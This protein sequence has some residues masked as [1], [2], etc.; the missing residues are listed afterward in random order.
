MAWPHWQTLS[1]ASELPRYGKYQMYVD[2][3]LITYHNAYHTYSAGD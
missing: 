1:E 3:I 2:T